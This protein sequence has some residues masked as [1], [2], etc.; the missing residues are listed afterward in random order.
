MGIIAVARDTNNCK[1]LTKQKRCCLVIFVYKA[2][3]FHSVDR[4][5]YTYL[6]WT[7]D[8]IEYVAM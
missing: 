1:Y 3:P 2:W 6:P 5:L 4:S 7:V 8:Q